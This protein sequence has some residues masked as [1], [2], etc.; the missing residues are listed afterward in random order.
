MTQTA[1]DPQLHESGAKLLFANPNDP[2]DPGLKRYFGI[3]S[4]Y[5]RIR[6]LVEEEATFEAA[7]ETWRFNHKPDA[8]GPTINYWV[9][10][11]ATRP[12]DSG[13]A[14]YEYNIPLVAEDSVGEKKVNFQFRPSLPDATHV[15]T[16]NPI[17]VIPDDIPEGLR[18]QVAS[19]NVNPDDY[20]TIMEAMFRLVG[21]TTTYL[22]DLHP[23]S[24]LKAMAVYT[25]ILRELS[26]A[27]IV[28]RNG[29]LER[30]ARFSSVQRGRG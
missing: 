24:R 8:D 17:G 22:D 18:V 16:G 27:H 25:R 15:E 26:E 29:L 2:D 20:L 21:I 3:V 6:E 12:G 13:E 7:G 1:L 9:G 10:K 28:E 11:I 4:Q 19:A 30:L 14:Y 5:D 23:W